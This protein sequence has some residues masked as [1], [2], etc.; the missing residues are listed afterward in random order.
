MEKESQEKQKLKS[1][2][3]DK[4]ESHRIT[5]KRTECKINNTYYIT[6]NGISS[7][8]RAVLKPWVLLGDE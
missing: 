3:Q 1:I 4:K 8:L 5:G 6:M 7:H 2:S